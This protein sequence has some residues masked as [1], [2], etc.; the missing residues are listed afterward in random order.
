MDDQFRNRLRRPASPNSANPP[1]SAITQKID[2]P[3]PWIFVCRFW[4]VELFAVVVTGSMTAY[5]P[6]GFVEMASEPQL[7]CAGSPLQLAVNDDAPPALLRLKPP[8]TV[9]V[10]V[11]LA[12]CPAETDAGLNAIANPRFAPAVMMKGFEVEAV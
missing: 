6:S 8:V 9:I 4:A 3:E 10:P 2:V 11:M 5:E 12:V 1:G 7:V